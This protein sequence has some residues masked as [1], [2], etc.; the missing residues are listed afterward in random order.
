[1]FLVDLKVLKKKSAHCH[2]GVILLL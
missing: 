2:L 1:M